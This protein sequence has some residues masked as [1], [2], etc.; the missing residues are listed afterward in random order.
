MG[1][2]I[3]VTF[4]VFASRVASIALFTV[5]YENAGNEQRKQNTQ[6]TERHRAYGPRRLRPQVLFGNFLAELLVLVGY[7]ALRTADALRLVDGVSNLRG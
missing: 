5:P 7:G 1:W 4:N 2:T 6:R 3:S